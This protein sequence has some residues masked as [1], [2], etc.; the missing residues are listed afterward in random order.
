MTRRPQPRHTHPPGR[1]VHLKT[2]RPQPRHTHPPG[3]VVHLKT[4][5]PQLCHT[6]PL[7]RV[8][9]LM[10]RGVIR[11]TADG[12]AHIASTACDRLSSWHPPSFVS[13]AV[14]VPPRSMSQSA[15]PSDEQRQTLWVGGLSER[16]D[17]E[18]LYELFC[19]AGPVKSVKIPIDRETKK[20]KPFG[21]VLFHHPETVPF[22]VNLFKEVTLFG[23]SLRLQN[24]DTGAGM[25]EPRTPQNDYRSNQSH[26]MHHRSFSAPNIH[27]NGYNGPVHHGYPPPMPPPNMQYGYHGEQSHTPTGPPHHRENG[28]SYR[29]R[30]PRGHRREDHQPREDSYNRD[31]RRQRDRSYERRRD[32]PRR[33]SHGGSGG[34]R[35]WR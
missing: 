34:A 33:D 25:N 22:A 27:Q 7:G 6:H 9:H 11:N 26:Q 24:K 23:R 19:N 15:E 1:V 4:R 30:N 5:R 32:Y 2:R 20:Q 8:V 35:A 14:N 17:E 13:L 18:I 31:D 12:P 28:G 21:F 16:V 10:S 3:R 29:E